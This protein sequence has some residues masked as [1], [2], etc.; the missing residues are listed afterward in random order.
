MTLSS[1]EETYSILKPNNS[2]AS[3]ASADVWRPIEGAGI[4]NNAAA[5][6]YRQTRTRWTDGRPA[7]SHAGENKKG[8]ARKSGTGATLRRVALWHLCGAAASR[9]RRRRCGAWNGKHQPS[10]A[11]VMT[12]VAWLAGGCCWL[13]AWLASAK[14]R[15]S[16]FS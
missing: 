15:L 1:V 3:S 9:G 5:E 12:V 14:Q 2:S 10:S 6:G 13:A 11:G 16:Y 7:H 8:A 4:N